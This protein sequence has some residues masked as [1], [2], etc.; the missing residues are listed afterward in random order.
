M[1]RQGGGANP[2]FALALGETM[3]RVGQ[4]YIAWA[5]YERAGR[6]A[7]RFWPGPAVQQSLRDHCRRAAAQIE[8]TLSFR[9]RTRDRRPPWQ[10]V[11]PPPPG[12][13]GGR[14]R[15]SF[16]AELALGEGYR[17]A[18]QQYEA[19]KIAAGVPITD[20]HVFDEFHAGRGRS[21]PRSGRRSGSP[22]C[23]G[24][25][26]ARM[27]LRGQSAWGVFGA[28]LAAMGSALLSRRRL[29]RAAA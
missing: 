21:P 26:S 14:L 15:P 11:S 1:W 28:G 25:G 19:A 2:H 3:L 16:D 18:Y 9:G 20:T 24:R 4:R 23:R 17:R 6:M 27:C 13:G 29:R 10:H 7:D 8:E 12:R 5:A 22:G